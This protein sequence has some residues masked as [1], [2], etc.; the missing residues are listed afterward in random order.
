MG[1]TSKQMRELHELEERAAWLDAEIQ[2]LFLE[3]QQVFQR[4]EDLNMIRLEG[5]QAERMK[6]APLPP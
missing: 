4:I 5:L 6:A 1:L 2:K 3:R